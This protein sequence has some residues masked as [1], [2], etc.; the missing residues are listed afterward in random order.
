MDRSLAL[1]AIGL[2]FGGGIGFAIA[3]SNGVTFDGHDHGDPAAH[4]GM[5]HGGADHA[6]MHDQPL[7]LPPDAAPQISMTIARDPMAGYNLHVMVQDFAF[8]PQNAS[9]E[10]TPGE[11]HAHVY[12]NGEKLG[13]LYAPWL[14][15]AEL[16]KGEVTVEVTL[17]SNDHRP[18]AVAGVPITAREVLRVE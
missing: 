1:F 15:I 17:N 9:G 10:N 12:I 6:M 2:V 11:G 5:D 14:H 4:G 18:L 8:S 3:A 7:D 13:R 16:P